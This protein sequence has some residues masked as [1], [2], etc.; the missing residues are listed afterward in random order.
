MDCEHHDVFQNAIDVAHIHYLVRAE[1]ERER[2]KEREGK[3][4]FF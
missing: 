1:G 3:F 4:F 2:E